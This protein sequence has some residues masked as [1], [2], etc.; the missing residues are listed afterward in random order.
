MLKQVTG[1]VLAAM[2]IGSTAAVVSA[3]ETE[4]NVAATAGAAV[5]VTAGASAA[6]KDDGEA[7]GATGEDSVA[8]K[9]DSAATGAGN[10]IYFD[11]NT[12]SWKNFKT[13]TFYAYRHVGDKYIDWGS[14]KGN[15]TDNDKDG[16]WEFD[17]DKA[18]ITL[19][20]DS[21]CIFTAD[22]N[23]QTCNLILGPDSV[24]DTAVGTGGQVEVDVDSNKKC[25]VVKWKSGKYGNP[26][27][28]TSIGNIIGD[29]YWTGENA[30]TLLTGWFTDSDV[31]KNILNAVNYSGKTMQTLIDEAAVKLGVG[32]EEVKKIVADCK[33]KAKK[34]GI[35]LTQW[36]P[37]KSTLKP[38]NPK[39]DDQAQT[40]ATAPDKIKS[41]EA[42]YPGGSNTPGVS[43]TPGSSNTPGGG[44][45]SSVTTGEGMT[46]YLLLG[47]IALAAAGVI[48]LARKRNEE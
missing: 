2:L 10:K 43:N 8:A 42:T 30:T 19:E 9:D 5:E 32:W 13:I 1:V 6:A 23:T 37:D 38:A 36:D 47:G 14:K 33:D 26:M 18:G 15:M 20:K 12:V 21:A 29:Y 24:G 48:F 40:S 11:A 17:L 3:A 34:E 28:I 25:D 7:V 35:D 27:T 16:V 22:W 46:V 4:E 45:V 41:P 39:S 44:S 31:K